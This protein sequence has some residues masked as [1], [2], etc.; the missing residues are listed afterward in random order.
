MCDINHYYT[1]YGF[2]PKGI[3]AEYL[4]NAQ[5]ICKVHLKN[6]SILDRVTFDTISY[7]WKHV[8]QIHVFIHVKA[9]IGALERVDFNSVS[10]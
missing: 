9:Q 1:K 3:K 7:K 6:E 8:I 5:L 2:A 4:N 10:T